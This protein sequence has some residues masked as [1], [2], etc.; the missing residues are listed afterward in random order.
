MI[1]LLFSILWGGLLT[2][3]LCAPYG[4]YPLFLVVLG[5]S[6]LMYFIARK[7]FKFSNRY[8]NAGA[9]ALF[10]LSYTLCTYTIFKP[11]SFQFKG[12]SNLDPGKKAVIFYSEGEME[13]YTPYYAN[14]FL[15]NIPTL[16]K[17]LY[18]MQLK[19]EYRQIGVNTKNLD[20]L[21]IAS[22]VKNSL[23]NYKPYYFYIALSGYV[24]GLKDSIYS[25]LAD[26]CSEIIIIN[27]SADYNVEEKPSVK[28]VIEKARE[29]GVKISFTKPVHSSKSFAEIFSSTIGNMPMKFDGILI[30][31][32]ENDTSSL[33]KSNL[34]KYGY[35]D[36]DIIITTNIKNAMDYF[37]N[38][39]LR[40]V[41][42]INLKD[43][44]SGLI[45]QTITSKEFEKYSGGMKVMGKD[46]WGYDKRLIKPAI[47]V[48][49]E[50]D[51]K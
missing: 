5:I 12:I 43:S 24:P 19:K 39:N 17:P 44:S 51:K 18:T 20:L 23:L 7:H 38:R 42:Y 34:L 49:L 1:I 37:K 35:E 47:D 10:F 3:I 21:K 46:S 36:S 2:L 45:F 40:S 28:S 22:D 11:A 6:I 9:A 32:N 33:I 14:Y 15:E 4:Y 48:L 41:F 13:K 50:I 29:A 16:L 27:Y 31:D 25:A 30:I 26:G 8:F